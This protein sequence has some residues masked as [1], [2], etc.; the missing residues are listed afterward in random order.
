MS[1][2]VKL[3]LTIMCWLS[4]MR[5]FFLT[6]TVLFVFR[7]L[8]AEPRRPVNSNQSGFFRVVADMCSEASLRVVAHL[9]R[10]DVCDPT[11]DGNYVWCEHI[12]ISHLIIKH[13]SIIIHHF[14]HCTNKCDWFFLYF[15]YYWYTNNA[16]ACRLDYLLSKILVFANE[17]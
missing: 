14:Q 2:E 1:N 9:C 17:V 8:W 4:H 16:W 10:R 5:F 3:P 12:F 15:S 6:V 7:I 13:V 11:T